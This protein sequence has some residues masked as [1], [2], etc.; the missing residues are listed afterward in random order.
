VD[1]VER[2]ADGGLLI[3]ATFGGLY[4][5]DS[6]LATFETEDLFDDEANDRSV[7]RDFLD[8][9]HQRLYTLYATSWSKYR[10]LIRIVEEGDPAEMQR[11]WCLLGMG[12]K[13][14]AELAPDSFPF[15]RY[16]GLF[17]QLARPVSAL[18]A[19]LKDALRI[20][21][22]EIIQCP[23]RLVR[24]PEELQTAWL[25]GTLRQ[26]LFPHLHESCLLHYGTGRTA[27]KIL[28][29]IK[30]ADENM[31]QAVPICNCWCDR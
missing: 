10:T 24:I 29:L 19:I 22:V 17:A 8:I 11:A 9:I 26:S 1:T 13:E 20:D 30:I 31:F 12:E 14:L 21:R 5:V 6:P 7:V 28:E 25:I 23:R 18:E 15:L 4:G 2:T 16:S 3:T 27:G